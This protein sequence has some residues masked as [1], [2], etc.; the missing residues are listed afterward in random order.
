MVRIAHFTDA[1][2]DGVN[3]I[4]TSIRLLTGAL[5]E[6]GHES[7]VVSAGPLRGRSGETVRV[8]SVP[9]GMGDFRFSLFPLRGMRDRVRDWRPDVAHVHTPGPLGA[10]GMTVARGLGIPAVYTYHTDMHGY[11]AFYHFPTPVIRAGTALYARALPRGAEAGGRGRYAAVEAANARVF[12]AARVILLP[13]ANALRH[14]RS[15]PAYAG[16]VR[17]VATPPPH[18]ENTRDGAVFRQRWGMSPERPVILF[19]GRL[20][21]EKGIPLLIEAVRELPDATLLLVGPVCRRLGLHRR[22][23][24]AGIAART[25]VTGALHGEDVL[26]A[27]R[28]ATVFAFPST[29]DTQGIVLHEAALAGLPLVMVDR[30]L[31]AGHPLGPAARLAGP[32][33]SALASVLRALL[34]D[35]GGAAE[36]GRRARLIA[37]A[38]T[39][40]L[41]AERTLDAYREALS[42][43]PDRG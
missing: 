4:A 20:A 2:V 23:A 40:D 1:S 43:L 25:V 3:G 36:A 33:P 37:Y 30:E 22:L 19:V 31:A 18:G 11:S 32:A 34:D 9:T 29:T 16:K 28:A 38:L 7:L 24:R 10:A 6:R 17:V 27:Y 26:S 12:E 14:C 21:G 42:L 13:T 39:P 5:G 15:A 41:F 35:P 8:P